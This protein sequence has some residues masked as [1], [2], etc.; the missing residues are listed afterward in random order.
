MENFDEEKVYAE[1][2]S[3][4][5]AQIVDLCKEHGIPM[6]SSFVY[7]NN[8]KSTGCCVT[9]INSIPNRYCKRVHIAA[10]MFTDTPPKFFTATVSDKESS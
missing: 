8:D 6:V 7:R 9:A 5:V 2:I 10:E 4:L 3:P 1:K